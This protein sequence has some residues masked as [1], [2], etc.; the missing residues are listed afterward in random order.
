MAWAHQVAAGTQPYSAGGIGEGDLFATLACR[1]NEG[2]VFVDQ[3]RVGPFE[4]ALEAVD[5]LLFRNFEM[6][7]LGLAAAGGIAVVIVA[8]RRKVGPSIRSVLL[9]TFPPVT[10]LLVFSRGAMIHPF[11]TLSAVPGIALLAALWM[12]VLLPALRA[13]LGRYA[14]AAIAGVIC[15]GVVGPE[16][17]AG[18]DSWSAALPE[19]RQGQE[20]LDR[21]AGALD[22]RLG[23]EDHVV[24]TDHG[25]RYDHLAWM[26]DR[27][28]HGHVGSPAA[29]D[30][31]CEASGGQV[32]AVMRD[33]ELLRL[34][35]VAGYLVDYPMATIGDG[36]RLFDLRTPPRE[37]TPVP[38]EYVVIARQQAQAAPALQGVLKLRQDDSGP[39]IVLDPPYAG[40]V[41]LFAGISPDELG[42]LHALDPRPGVALRR[43]PPGT[44]YV[45]AVPFGDDGSLGG[46]TPVLHVRRELDA[47]YVLAALLAVLGA[48]GFAAG[49]YALLVVPSRGLPIGDMGQQDAPA[50][51]IPQAESAR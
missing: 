48:L 34:P 32:V 39:R 4:G 24:V 30:A 21:L 42:P 50:L 14:T 31:I 1:V 37:G 45:V 51:D 13:E 49:M 11:W 9:V 33:V 16:V 23:P 15:F 46:A 3:P 25:V 22:G 26:L 7:A 35:K 5:T 47:G 8:F 20:T 36:L 40:R 17:L 38:P 41:M 44:W 18:R 2:P 28:V 19:L 10:F 12:A 43:L 29:V 6:G 27:P